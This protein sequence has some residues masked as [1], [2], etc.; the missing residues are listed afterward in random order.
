MTEKKR[1][2]QEVELETGTVW[3][4]K[5][6]IEGQLLGT[7]HNVGPND[8]TMYTVAVGDDEVKVWGSTVLDDKLKNVKP[9]SFVK[10]EYEGKLKSKK[11]TEY[12]SYKVFVDMDSLPEDEG[13]METLDFDGD[14]NPEELPE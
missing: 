8:S 14:I 12:H 11:G 4:K 10:I 6:P 13:D 1:N 5:E 7:E 3:D 9:G 2:Y